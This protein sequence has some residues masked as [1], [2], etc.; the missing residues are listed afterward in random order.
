MT[1]SRLFQQ[2]LNQSDA[3]RH[4]A[5]EEYRHQVTQEILSHVQGTSRLWIV[6]AGNMDDLDLPLLVDKFDQVMLSDIDQ[7]AMKMAIIRDDVPKEKVKLIPLDVTGLES[8][9][10]L[11][12]LVSRIREANSLEEIEA[13]FSSWK[14][15][16]R[17][18]KFPSSLTKTYDMILVSPIFTQLFYPQIHA[19]IVY[20]RSQKMDETTLRYVEREALAMMPELFDQVLAKM[21]QRISSQTV[22]VIMS[23]VFEAQTNSM[24]Y[25]QASSLRGSTPKM[26]DFYEDYLSQYGV[27]LGD[28]A[29]H[30]LEETNVPV[31]HRWFDWPFDLQRHL[32]VKLAVYQGKR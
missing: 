11:E 3:T 23:D 16:I 26:D 30:R 25:K 22:L 12:H 7:E 27:G 15:S 9:P 13:M 21:E 5:W 8:D 32:F 18:F 29:F 24:F 17:R 14:Q 31:Y 4:M 20:L 10:D 19:T 6:G 2:E 1:S 28:Y